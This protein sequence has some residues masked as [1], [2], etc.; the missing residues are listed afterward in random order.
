MGNKLIEVALPLDAIN[1]AAARE[2]S[3][4]HFRRFRTGFY[5]GLDPNPMSPHAEDLVFMEFP[6]LDVAVAGFASW[7]GLD[8]FCH[9]GEINIASLVAARRL[10]AGSTVPVVV[11]VWHHSIVGGPR[12]HDYMDERIVHKLILRMRAPVSVH[13]SSASLPSPS[14]THP[15]PVHA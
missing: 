1:S 6:A 4:R 15:R 13:C 12:S 14:I 3:I 8:C 7:H 9:V 5:A 11:A 10:I 2:K